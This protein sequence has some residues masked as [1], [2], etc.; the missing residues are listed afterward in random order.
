MFSVYDSSKWNQLPVLVL[1]QNGYFPRAKNKIDWIHSVIKCPKFNSLLFDKKNSSPWYL[2][3]DRPYISVF[4]FKCFDYK[5]INQFLLSC[6]FDLL[7]YWIR[8]L[9]ENGLHFKRFFHFSL[10]ADYFDTSLLFIKLNCLMHF[11]QLLT[12]SVLKVLCQWL[13]VYVRILCLYKFISSIST[14]MRNFILNKQP[15]G[16]N[17]VNY[18]YKCRR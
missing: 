4:N 18:Y 8:F 10:A 6:Y 1:E 17:D 7:S 12:F 15:V 9:Q 5:F 14:W 2:I 11:D 13:D 3:G 16:T